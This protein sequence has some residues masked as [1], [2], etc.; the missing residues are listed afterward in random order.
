M[1]PWL[2]DLNLESYTPTPIRMKINNAALRI[3]NH[4]AHDPSA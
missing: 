2:W 4:R 3:T 1:R